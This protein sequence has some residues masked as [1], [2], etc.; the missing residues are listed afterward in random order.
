MYGKTHILVGV[1]V[2]TNLVLE[3]INRFFSVCVNSTYT[4]VHKI[5]ASLIT[6]IVFVINALLCTDYFI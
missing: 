5:V 2:T 3:I 4:V 1:G 6:K